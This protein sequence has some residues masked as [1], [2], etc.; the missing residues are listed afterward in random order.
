VKLTLNGR[1]GNV[2]RALGPAL[3]AEGHE[4]VE[5]DAA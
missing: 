4:L 3:E 2:G 1:G 5:L